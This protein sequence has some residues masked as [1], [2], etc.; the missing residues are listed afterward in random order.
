MRTLI[1]DTETTGRTD[2]QAIEIAWAELLDCDSLTVGD[3]G[4]QRY[5]PSKAIE[6]GA[7]ATHH[8]LPSDLEGCPPSS[9]YSL[10]ANCTY[11]IGHNVD[12]DWTVIGKPEVK[13][14]CTLAMART[15]WPDTD[16]HTLSALMYFLSR[17]Q[18]NTRTALQKAHSALADVQ[19]TRFLLG[20]ILKKHPVDSWE[21]LWEYSE[22]CRIPTRM[23]FGKHRGVA[24]AD[25]PADYVAWALRQLPDADPYLRQAL[26]ER[27]QA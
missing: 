23:P 13:R 7:M 16:S 22:V 27:L 6:F 25:L 15:L 4:S 18:E 14:I 8:I 20:N 3:H 21:E 1:L 9:S 24:I 10:P 19:F 2:P 17:N 12:Y 5:Q 26:S 11:L